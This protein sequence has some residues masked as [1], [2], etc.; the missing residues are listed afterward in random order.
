[1]SEMFFALRDI[2]NPSVMNENTVLKS[3]IL[4]VLPKISTHDEYLQNLVFVLMHILLFIVF[5]KAVYS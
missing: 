3:N 5:F 2:N 1:M 4:P